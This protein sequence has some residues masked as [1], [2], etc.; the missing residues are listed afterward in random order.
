MTQRKSAQNKPQTKQK[1]IEKKPAK[2]KFTKQVTT[3][4]EEMANP[5]TK[6][7]TEAAIKAG[8]PPASA[9]VTASRWL[10]NANISA[11][12]QERINRSLAHTQ[13]TKEE[14][15]GSAVR[16]M[17]SSMNDVL[18]ARGNFDIDRARANGSIDF[19]RKL[20]IKTVTDKE[21]GNVE[22]THEIEMYSNQ[23]GRKEVANYIGLEKT[24]LPPL[25]L[26]L[27]EELAREMCRRM[28]DKH[29]W[30]PEMV[31]EK[32]SQT[33][34]FQTLDVEVLRKKFAGQ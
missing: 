22:T 11:E 15:L 17:R 13:V 26:L 16:Q 1:T 34:R 3:F 9:R 25:P 12:I 29:G 20:R 28:I 8:S 7:A 10:T 24:P 14:V 6:S 2:E 18:D 30:T 4:I 31:I 27:D 23:D 19:I 32:I 5:A 33:P 21:T